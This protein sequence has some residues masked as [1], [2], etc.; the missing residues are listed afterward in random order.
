MTTDD[1]ERATA[2]S[3]RPFWQWILLGVAPGL[4]GDLAAGL[5]S[6]IDD[7]RG[8]QDLQTTLMMFLLGLPLLMIPYLIWLSKTYV[9]SRGPMYG[10]S[11]AKFV[12]GFCVVNAF[13]WGGSCLIVLSNL[14]MQ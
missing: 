12:L 8:L 7:V 4:L 10:G 3:S 13:L 6:A 11:R 9:E 14:N 1:P 5:L 2:T